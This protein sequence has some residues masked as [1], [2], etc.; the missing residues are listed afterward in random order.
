MLAI[1]VLMFT[2]P[3]SGIALIIAYTLLHFHWRWRRLSFVSTGP[4][5]GNERLDDILRT[6]VVPL[7]ILNGFLLVGIVL[8][9][10]AGNP[11]WI[12]LA[13][14]GTPLFI[15]QLLVLAAGGRNKDTWILGEE[16]SGNDSN[17]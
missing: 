15:L 16:D 1:T 14:A 11:F 10:N 8:L 17:R 3:G 13:I 2:M 7:A 5:T 9:E 6:Y 12:G 4:L